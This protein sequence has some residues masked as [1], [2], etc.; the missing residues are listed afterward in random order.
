MRPFLRWIA[1]LATLWLVVITPARLEAVQ[2]FDPPLSQRVVAY[3]IDAR[4][5]AEKKTLDATEILTYRNLTG[6]PLD[7]FPFHLYLNA[8][9][10]KATFIQETR[11]YSPKFR[12][13]E[14]YRSSI[15]VESFEV[16][17]IGDLTE[18]IEFI[19][20]DDGNPDDRTVFQVRLPKPVPP[21]SGVQFKIAFHVQ[22]PLTLARTGYRRNF[23][24]LAQW[25][26]KVGVWWRGAWN[27]HQFHRTSEFFADFG[28]Y[29]VRL[30]VPQ[31]FVLGASGEEVASVNNPDGTKTVTYH[32]EDVHDFAWTADPN[33]RVVEDSWT[34]SAG[35]VKIRLLM[36]PGHLDQVPRYLDTLKGTLEYFD[37]W[38]GP[39]PYNR[40]TVVDPAH[41][42][43]AGGMEYPTLITAGTT[44]WMPRGLLMPELVTEHEFGHQY[45]YGIVANNE[46]EDAWLDEGINS[47]AEVKVMEA[48][49][50]PERS[51][52]NLW[53]AT[54]GERASQ[55]WG[56]RDYA[57]TDP[58]VR[59]SYE[60]ISGGTYGAVSYNKATCVLLTLEGLIGEETL[61]QALHIYFMRY[62]FTHPT[63]EDFLR[64]VEEVA[65]QDLRWYFDQ[66]VYGT[67]KFDYAIRTLRSDRLDWFQKDRP[68]AKKGET[69]YRSL[70]IVQRKGDF[71]F[72]CEIEIKFDN[73]EMVR[74]YWDGRDRWVKFTYEKKAKVVSAEID[75]DH[76]VFLDVNLFNDS[77]TSERH[78]GATGKLAAL[79]LFLTQFLAQ[80][81]AW[82]A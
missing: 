7:T 28:T 9:Q 77:Y 38:Y 75:P 73:G 61:R 59:N 69:P 71:I 10:P 18:R 33:Y 26:P 80:L 2:H 52:I 66:A 44:W 72:P 46:F 14:E 8:F 76:K 74:E 81:L 60:F 5:D 63:E 79:W 65:G 53:G 57:D 41:G 78:R 35:E 22:L 47:Y 13:K 62:R 29:D 70:V 49:F 25:F 39:Y 27:C 6:Q 4:L 20:P 68:P 51:V 3:E 82:L 17:G 31:N 56:F 34:G 11:A 16:V 48:L 43:R 40:I 42:A 32:A 50:G 12:W 64:T 55:R 19:Q 37:R 1:Y 45:W 67:Q 30:T 21:G 24:M 54:A 58:L 15:R 23:F 36:Q